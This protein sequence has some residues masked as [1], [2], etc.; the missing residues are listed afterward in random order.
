MDKAFYKRILIIIMGICALVLLF[1]FISLIVDAIG[2]ADLM[3]NTS[4]SSIMLFAKWS[5]VAIVCLMVPLFMSYLFSCLS[6]NVIFRISSAVLSLFTAVSAIAFIAV[7]RQIVLDNWS[8]SDYT[9]FTAYMQEMIQV[10]VPS[11][12]GC[13]FYTVGS[14]QAFAKKSDDT[15]KWGN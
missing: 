9:V 5:S 13:I 14:I 11:I 3:E 7:S 2:F 12:I 8:T 1:A 4:V 6:K 10:L 15:S